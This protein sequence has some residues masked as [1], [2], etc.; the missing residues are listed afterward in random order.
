MRLGPLILSFALTACSGSDFRGGGSKAS[1]DKDENEVVASDDDDEIDEQALASEPAMV[2]GSFLH[3]QAFPGNASAKCRIQDEGDNLVPLTGVE[4]EWQVIDPF[5]R[6]LDKQIWDSQESDWHTYAIIGEKDLTTA[7]VSASVSAK[8]YTRTLESLVQPHKDM[9]VDLG[10]FLDNTFTPVGIGD[11][12]T[13]TP[14]PSNPASTVLGQSDDF[15]LGDDNFSAKANRDCADGELQDTA[16]AGKKI[17]F[18]L[19]VVSDSVNI[20]VIL[21]DVCGATV[22]KKNKVRIEKDGVTLVEK[23]IYSSFR[24]HTVSVPAIKATKGTYQLVIESQR[25]SDGDY[26]DFVVGEIRF[27]VDGNIN[28]GDGVAE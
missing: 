6:D 16:L 7:R 27:N 18:P 11:P 2:S 15:Q 8:G 19:E 13:Q 4:I 25:K 5:N 24:N 21:D 1:E 22:Y 28:I 14:T 12:P 9:V 23:N 10:D 17:S 3:C 20:G 26:D